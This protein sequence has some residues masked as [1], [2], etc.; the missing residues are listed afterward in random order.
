[1]GNADKLRKHLTVVLMDLYHNHLAFPGAY[2]AYSRNRSSYGGP[3]RYNKLHIKYRP[4]MHVIDG[5]EELG[6]IDNAKG[7]FDRHL[8]L[9]F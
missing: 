1:M 5:L 7:F 2:T 8:L 6:Y 9:T 4:L 3:S